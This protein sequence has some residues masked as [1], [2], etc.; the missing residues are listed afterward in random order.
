[1]AGRCCCAE[2][3]VHMLEPEFAATPRASDVDVN[4]E[5]LERLVAFLVLD[6]DN[7]A[8]RQEGIR[9]ACRRGRWSSARSLI[10][11]GLLNS[12]SDLDLRVVLAYVEMQEGRVQKAHDLLSEE[13]VQAVPTAQV[14]RARCLLQLHRVPEA[15]DVCRARLAAADNDA[16]CRGLLALLLCDSG[17]FEGA[18]HHAQTALKEVPKQLE[19]RLTLMRLLQRTDPGE[20]RAGY[21]EIVAA[22]PGC[23]RAWLAL[24]LLDLA[25]EELED[26]HRSVSEATRCQPDHIGTWHVLGWVHVLQRD[27]ISAERAFLHALTLDRS[28]GETHGALAVVAAMQ[29]RAAAARAAMRRAEKLDPYSMA[30]RYAELLLCMAVDDLDGAQAVLEKALAFPARDSGVLYRDLI[31]QQLQLAKT[32]PDQR[33]PGTVLH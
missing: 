22:H 3:Q 15:L 24:A 18:A 25:S 12:P 1:M 2:L 31:V 6:P 13:V 28:F 9:E 33:P 8:L 10:E 11:K 19:A 30:A 16:E 20:A 21:L 32:R 27:A 5:R 14:L 7:K 17:D 23:G 4:M 29:G 26:A